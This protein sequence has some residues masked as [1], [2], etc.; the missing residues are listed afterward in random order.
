[1]TLNQ[2]AQH[3]LLLSSFGVLVL[4]GFALAY[5]GSWLALLLG[6]SEP[7]R[8]I[9]HR[10]AGVVMLLAAFYHLFYTFLTKEGRDS[11]RGFLPRVKDVKDLVQNM[12]YYLGRK[13]SRPEFGRFGYAEKAEY[14]AVIW[15]TIVMGLTGLMI[16]F[17]V[18][19]FGFLPRW[20]IDVATAVHF[21]EAVLATL[22]IIVWHFYHVIFDPDVYPL[23]WAVLD[24]KVSE[25][26]YKH[27]H[28]LDYQRALDESHSRE[29][30]G[31]G[32]APIPSE[33]PGQPESA[34]DSP[35][36]NRLA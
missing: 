25:Q 1:M 29:S 21:Y 9:A 6:S 22:A 14:W 28:P 7:F 31:K 18:G 34:S 5:P 32:L 11:L 24:G 19:W 2:R 3:W 26:F 4:T 30:N 13:V 8:R 17:K 15:G 35:A 33:R 36:H 23:N 20:A 12:G 16:W 27:E 10:V